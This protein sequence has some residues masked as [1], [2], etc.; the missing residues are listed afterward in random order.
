[1]LSVAKKAGIHRKRISLSKL[2]IIYEYC[3]YYSNDFPVIYSDGTVNSLV[4]KYLREQVL[5]AFEGKAKKQPIRK[6]ANLIFRV[7]GWWKQD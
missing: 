7:S 1:M 6:T 3:T 5:M 2:R 4:Q